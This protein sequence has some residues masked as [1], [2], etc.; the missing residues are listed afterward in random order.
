MTLIDPS[1]PEYV[2]GVA[3]Y[4][5]PTEDLGNVI[6]KGCWVADNRRETSSGFA[7]REEAESFARLRWGWRS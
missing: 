7:S 3:I 4:Y 6:I 5:R 1:E 2:N